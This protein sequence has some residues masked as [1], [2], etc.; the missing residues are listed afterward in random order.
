MSRRI[1]VCSWSLQPAN[2]DELALQVRAAGCRALQLHL[3]PLRG[4]W[5]E[6]QTIEALQGFELC[7][8]M[9]S[10]EGEDYTTLETIKRTGGVR[11]DETWE[12]NLTAAQANAAL[13]ER[14]GITL[15]TFH[16]GWI[17]HE[18]SDPERDTMVDR[19]RA[20]QRVFAE[21]G[22]VIALETGQETAETLLDVLA[23]LPG[24][25][26][27]FDPAN[28]LL[29]AMGDPHDALEQLGE[30]VVQLHIKDANRTTM[31][32]TWGEEV[33]V[34][35]G[36]VDWE[37]FLSIADRVCPDVDLLIEREAG[38]QRVQDIASA[39]SMLEQMVGVAG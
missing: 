2:H 25:G 31:P 8:G 13:A 38:T 35:E 20:L 22:V 28:M 30:R 23:E 27:N 39:R 17:P 36:E 18:E 7:S 34:G 16:A 15:V 12:Q 32:G 21:H 6:A 11:P 10:M 24:V 1:G 19:L 14:L 33:P 9:M 29:Y 4:G 26:V 37:R 5:D 3:D